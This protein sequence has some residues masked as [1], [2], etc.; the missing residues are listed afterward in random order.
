[1]NSNPVAKS[2]TLIEGTLSYGERTTFDAFDIST[3]FVSSYD[4]TLKDAN[5]VSG[6]EFAVGSELS[7]E[8]NNVQPSTA[9]ALI[10]PLNFKSSSDTSVAN[11]NANNKI[12]CLKAGSTTLT[13]VSDS[14]V[15]KTVELTVK[16]DGIEGVAFSNELTSVE[17]IKVG[18]T[19]TFTAH[20]VPNIENQAINVSIKSGSEFATLTNNSG[21]YTLTAIAGG[22]VTI[23]ASTEFNG[24]TF[25]CEH[26][27]TIKETM[28]TEDVIELFAN[29]VFEDKNAFTGKPNN[30]IAFNEG[31]GV[32]T[33]I[34]SS[35]DITFDYEVSGSTITISNVV[36]GHSSF[37]L[38]KVELADDGSSVTVTIKNTLFGSSTSYTMNKV[39]RP[40]EILDEDPDADMEWG[41][42]S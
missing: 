28:K 32:Y 18:Q 8:Y 42:L 33:S 21:S 6:S 36:S 40:I 20:S 16:F 15:E 4:V 10:D 22:T 34:G 24:Q 29:Y 38:T 3:L 27:I 39:K 17:T 2:I 31:K 12:E 37:T 26:T 7:F 11:I 14:G 23:E 1:M 41:S 13:F 35:Y 5:G 19:V 25:T 9:N 30:K